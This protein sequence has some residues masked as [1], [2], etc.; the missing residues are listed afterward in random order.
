MSG[1]NAKCRRKLGKPAQL[2]GADAVKVKV[3]LGKT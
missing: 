2:S 1:K 3:M